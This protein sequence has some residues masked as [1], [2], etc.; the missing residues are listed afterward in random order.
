MFAHLLLADFLARLVVV[1]VGVTKNRTG[2][3]TGRSLETK[4]RINN[5]KKWRQLVTKEYRETTVGSSEMIKKRKEKTGHHVT[6]VEAGCLEF[7]FD[8]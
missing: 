7:T 1:V 8:Y 3:F 5:K 6:C 2:S 4:T